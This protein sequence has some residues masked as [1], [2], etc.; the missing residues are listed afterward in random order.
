MAASRTVSSISR[1]PPGWAH[2]LKPGRD[3]AADEH[4]FAAVGDGQCRDHEPRVDVEDEAAA[5]AGEPV[6]L[7]V[8]DRAEREPVAAARAETDRRL[9]PVGD[10]ARAESDF[11]HADRHAWAVSTRAERRHRSGR[12]SIRRPRS[13]GSGPR[14]RPS[15][16]R[17]APDRRGPG[18]RPRAGRRSRRRRRRPWPRGCPWASGRST[19]ANPRPPATWVGIGTPITGQDRLGRDHAGQ[20]RRAAGAGDEDADAALLGAG[21]EPEQQVRRPMG[22]DGVQ[23]ARNLEPAEHLDGLLHHGEVRA[24]AADDPDPRRR[25]VFGHAHAPSCW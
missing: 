2:R 21:H 20:M 9:E 14:G 4:H 10:A 25:P 23:L 13:P 3:A 6:S 11:A 15:A 5:R 1:K 8:L 19:G 18:S 22:R 7:L 24:A 12:R 17:A 16:D